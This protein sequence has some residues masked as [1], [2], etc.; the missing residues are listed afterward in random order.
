M[1]HDILIPMVLTSFLYVENLTKIWGLKN[2][3][4]KYHFLSLSRILLRK[5][6]LDL[7]T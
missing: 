5:F 6:T 1:N 3:P 7:G 4:L 2:A